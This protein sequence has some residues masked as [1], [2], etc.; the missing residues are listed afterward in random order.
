MSAARPPGRLGHSAVR[1]WST[2][3]RGWRR[4]WRAF[5]DKFPLTLLGLLVGAAAG[6]ALWQLGVKHQDHVLY[7]ATAGVLALLIVLVVA[8]TV[9]AVAY[10]D[11]LARRLRA[12]STEP[13]RLEAGTS[14]ES[15]FAAPGLA[16]LP[17]V[18]VSW[19]WAEPT[20]VLVET[21]V[22]HGQLV[23]EVMFAERGE[24][25]RVVRRVILGDVFGLVRLAFHVVE[26]R[27]RIVNPA[28]G[29]PL[30]TPLLDSF[31]GGDHLSHP[32]GPPDGD[33]LEMRRYAAGDPMK[34]ILWKTYARARQ[35]MVRVPERAI[36]P[37]RRTL[38]FLVADH[39]DEAAAAV[40]RLAVESG[41]L[42]PDWRFSSDLP[43]SGASTAPA[44]LTVGAGE[45]AADSR[46]AL[47]LIIRSHATRGHGGEGLTSFL[48][49]QSSFGVGRCVVFAP[50]RRGPWVELV[51]E[52]IRRQPGRFEVVLGTDGV[53]GTGARGRMRR[54]F[55]AEALGD[56]DEA[57]FL[58]NSRATSDEI[59]ALSRRLAGSGATV[60]TVDRP[61]GKAFGR[62]SRRRRA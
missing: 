37:T 43:A 4:G 35:L 46:H 32:L 57:A 27:P 55:L 25:P 36:S 34:W 39:G 53:Q 5:A 54:F 8:V 11:V 6:L 31:A 33:R 49:R 12:T 7:V 52:Q 2:L 48:D 14:I 9:T 22:R 51:E 3:S 38:A 41:A 15:G 29:R 13:V 28:L 10:H 44:V 16:F 42:G 60:I 1:A 47:A 61:T 59:E 56:V 23:E 24:Y 19:E 18:S 50:A 17:L 30:S 26:N 62:S 20:A 21:H 45:D 58:A 40:A